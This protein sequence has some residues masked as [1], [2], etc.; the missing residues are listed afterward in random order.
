M[1]SSCYYSITFAVEINES[2]IRVVF[3]DVIGAPGVNIYTND[4]DTNDVVTCNG[5]KASG[6]SIDEMNHVTISIRAEAAG[7][8]YKNAL[9]VKNVCSGFARIQYKEF[10][11]PCEYNPVVKTSVAPGEY[12]KLAKSFT[13]DAFELN[14]NRRKLINTIKTDEMDCPGK[15]AYVIIDCWEGG[16]ISTPGGKFPIEE[17]YRI[18]PFLDGLSDEEGTDDVWYGRENNFALQCLCRSMWR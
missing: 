13:H 7:A 11:W 5:I 12:I 18:D 16:S 4:Y 3:E 14:C 9:Y 15:Q 17:I 6:P 1:L 2:N 10:G 8:Q